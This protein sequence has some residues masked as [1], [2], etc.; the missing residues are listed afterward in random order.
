MAI[1]SPESTGPKWPPHSSTAGAEP[2]TSEKKEKNN[3]TKWHLF[4]WV[5]LSMKNIANDVD[6]PQIS[7][8]CFRK[9]Q[10]ERENKEKCKKECWIQY[11]IIVFI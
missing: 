1:T 4:F 5:G 6:Q 8:E 10:Q 7:E 3:K 9:K 2:P 11:K